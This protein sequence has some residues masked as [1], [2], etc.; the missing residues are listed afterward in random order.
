[1]LFVI[2]TIVVIVRVERTRIAL[3][4][5]K[6]CSKQS[7]A[8]IKFFYKAPVGMLK[9]T[10]ELPASLGPSQNKLILLQ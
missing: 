1:M 8:L 9:N 7:Q 10:L 3:L 5:D 2:L 4:K 6:H